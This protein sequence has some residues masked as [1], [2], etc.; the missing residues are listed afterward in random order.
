MLVTTLAVFLSLALV[1][2]AGCQASEEPGTATVQD[3]LKESGI[4]EKDKIS[5]GVATF[6]P[7]MGMQRNGVYSGFDIEIARY[8]AASLGF[9]GD[10]KIEFVPIATE[11]RVASLQGG[12]VDLVVA[13]FSITEERQKLIS[14]AGPYLVTTQEVLVPIANRDKIR[15]LEDLSNPEYR[16]C[17]SG[18]STTETELKRRGVNVLVLQTVR[19]CLNGVREGDYDAM[20]SD[21]TIL[22]GFR[23][24]YPGEFEIVDLPFGTSELLGIGVPIGNPAL[25]DLVAYFLNRSYLLGQ[26][27]QASPWLV[28]YNNTLGPWLGA[29]RTQP[30]PLEVPNLVDFTDKVNQQ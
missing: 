13:S 27:G 30:Q 5:I 12:R 1:V 3:K 8:I 24:E 19:D 26:S 25:R 28:A 6:E 15:T 17:A 10:D 22:A 2:T 18:G 9:A 16:I 4:Q 14:F 20:S 23:S 29:G 21:E 7:L 11:D